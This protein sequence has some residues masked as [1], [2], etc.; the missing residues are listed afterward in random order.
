V[1][2]E[3]WLERAE[4]YAVGAL[5]DTERTR[6]EAHL[7][8]EDC[9]SC[10]ARLKETQ[11]ALVLMPGSLEPVTPPA[12]VKSRLMAEIDAEG[13]G[14]TFIPAAEGEWQTPAHGVRVKILNLDAGRKRLTALVLMEPGSRYEDHRHTQPEEIYVLEGSCVCGGR[15]LCPGDYHRAERGSIH[16]DTRSETGSLM[17][18]IASAE[19]ER[20]E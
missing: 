13:L 10:R 14:F 6:F 19:N 11:E 15:L 4:S 16:L 18:V 12:A 7:S 9:A 3:E 5:E 20:L 1:D 8:S 2:H 17:L